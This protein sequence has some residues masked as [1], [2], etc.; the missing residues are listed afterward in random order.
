MKVIIK[1]LFIILFIIFVLA[2]VFLA[3]LYNPVSNS[4]LLFKRNGSEIVY[5][6]DKLAGLYKDENVE[7]SRLN[8]TRERESLL[9]KVLNTITSPRLYLF[10]FK[11][12]KNNFSVSLD[13]TGQT[14]MQ[15]IDLGDNFSINSSFYDPENRSIGEVIVNAKYH[16]NRTKSSGF[17]K[18]IDGVAWVGPR[19]L[20]YNKQG[21]VE[22][23]CQAHPSVMKNGV[24]WHYIKNETNGENFKERTFRNLSGINEAG[25]IVFLVSGEGG[26]LSVKEISEIAL[27]LN[28]KTATLFDAGSALQYQFNNKYYRLGFR[29]YNND[30]YLGAFPDKLITKIIGRKSYNSSPV[31]INYRY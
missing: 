18:V 9:K 25:N 12:N 27:K 29:V 26:L 14:A 4:H 23:S 2:T 3:G 31:F 20:F 24:I 15:R 1:S 8:F 13:E 21:T 28:V 11:I 17:F 22:Y 10:E 16:G 5:D 30:F 19:S 6:T 7:I